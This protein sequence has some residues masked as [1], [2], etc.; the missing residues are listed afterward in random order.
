VG[1]ESYVIVNAR[2]TLH[3]VEARGG[4]L[5]GFVD[6]AFWGHELQKDAPVRMHVE[7]PVA[8]LDSKNPA[9]DRELRRLI[10]TPSFPN[11]VA[12]AVEAVQQRACRYRIRG[13]IM[14]RGTTRWF[15]DDVSMRQ[16]DGRV[17]IDGDRTLDLRQFE[18]KLP[19]LLT[20]RVLPDV[21]VR[22]HVVAM[23]EE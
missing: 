6:A 14:I 10:A 11:V 2:S 20:F 21:R 4:G 17:E 15:H 12:D 18:I 5:R 19:H 7:I 23:M 8:N 3:A 13:S 16:R 22:L 9:Q 1:S